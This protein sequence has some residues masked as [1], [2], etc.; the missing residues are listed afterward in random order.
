MPTSSSAQSIP[1]N[2][3]G[4]PSSGSSISSP[5]GPS[6]TGLSPPPMSPELSAAQKSAS[7]NKTCTL[8]PSLIESEGTPQQIEGPYFVDGMP[9]RSVTALL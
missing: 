2:S 7:A 9:N 3:T 8:T 4:S 6:S 1:S 5:F